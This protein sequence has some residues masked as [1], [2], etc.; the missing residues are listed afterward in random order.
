MLIDKIKNYSVEDQIK[1]KEL[2]ECYMGWTYDNIEDLEDA[3]LTLLRYNYNDD[4]SLIEKEKITTLKR[5]VCELKPSLKHPGM[6][7]ES[8]V[9]E[10]EPLEACVDAE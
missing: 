3:I 5:L 8:L 6:I 7:E 4:L 10:L 1:I 2:I 9:E